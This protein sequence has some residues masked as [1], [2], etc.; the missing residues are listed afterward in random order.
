MEI[1]SQQVL[2]EVAQ[3][4]AMV[5]QPDHEMSEHS[6]SHVLV[7]T[8]AC[9][10]C[11]KKFYCVHA[12]QGREVARRREARRQKRVRSLRRRYTPIPVLEPARPDQ[13]PVIEVD[14]DTEPVLEPAPMF[15][16]SARGVGYQRVCQFW[17]NIVRRFQTQFA[18]RHFD[19][20]NFFDN[21]TNFPNPNP[22]PKAP[23]CTVSVESL[24][25]ELRLGV[26]GDHDGVD[27]T[28]KL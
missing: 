28:L 4:L 24:D 17:N 8:G 12:V 1:T 3:A 6:E 15:S 20:L 11:S 23:E 16:P 5:D 25:L 19:A 22:A 14:S 10:Y 9:L 18:E 2:P 21:N 27:V 26:A 13:V 7:S